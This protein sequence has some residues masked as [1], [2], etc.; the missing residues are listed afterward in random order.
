[1]DKETVE[2]HGCNSTYHNEMAAFT[3]D[4]IRALVALR[5]K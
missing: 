1:V 4:K 2:H 5:I 3:V